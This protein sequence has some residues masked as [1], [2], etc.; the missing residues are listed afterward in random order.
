[1]TVAVIQR[2]HNHFVAVN[3]RK[4]AA[5]RIYSDA[6]DALA[7]SCRHGFV[8]KVENVVPVELSVIIFEYNGSAA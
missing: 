4:I 1:M 5:P 6:L 3:Q 2:R 7:Y 8:H